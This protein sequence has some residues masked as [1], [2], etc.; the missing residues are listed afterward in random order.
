VS[1]AATSHTRRTGAIL[2]SRSFS[3][4]RTPEGAGQ[5]G[6]SSL[7]VEKAGTELA[8]VCREGVAE[9]DII[10]ETKPSLEG[11]VD[12]DRTEVQEFVPDEHTKHILHMFRAMDAS[13]SD[14]TD[15]D[16]QGVS[17]DP[18]GQIIL[19]YDEYRPRLFGYIR[20]LGLKRDDAEEVIQETFVQLTITLLNKSDID[21]VPGWIVRVAHNLAMNVFRRKERQAFRI[22]DVE[23]VEW[24]A[25][26]D[27]TSSPEETYL[28]EEQIQRMRSALATLNPQQRRCF[29]LRVQ[30]FRYKDIG[31]AL[32]ISEQR[33]G[34]IVNT[35]TDLLG[36]LCG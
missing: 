8:L 22:R 11:D 14:V 3:T 29:H 32:G 18:R 9:V 36:V 35:A 15:V 33:A 4:I 12:R 30:G 7:L 31:L 25:F 16:Q 23:D 19:L 13:D 10:G 6:L 34:R 26:I 2:L 20:S 5:R 24:E 27:P 28:K 17:A 21:N 1:F